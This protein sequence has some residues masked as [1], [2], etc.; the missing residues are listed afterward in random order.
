MNILSASKPDFFYPTSR[1]E[2]VLERMAKSHVTHLSTATF[3]NNH[4]IPNLRRSSHGLTRTSAI[5]RD[6]GREDI[7]QIQ[8]QNDIHP[9]NDVFLP[10]TKEQLP[11]DQRRSRIP[12]TPDFADKF[13]EQQSLLIRSLQYSEAAHHHLEDGDELYHNTDSEFFVHRNNPRSGEKDRIL[14]RVERVIPT[15]DNNVERNA[16]QQTLVRKRLA[17]SKSPTRFRESERRN[18]N[19]QIFLNEI[20]CMHRCDHPHI[21]KLVESYTD[22]NWFAIIM[23]PAAEM[24]LKQYMLSEP[25]H[26]AYGNELFSESFGCLLAALKHLAD[27]SIRHRDIKPENI[28]VVG[29]ERLVICDLGISLD[30]EEGPK[31]TDTNTLGTYK[32]KAPELLASN[33]EHDEKTDIWALA[34]VYVEMFTVMC[35]SKLHDLDAHLG[36]CTSE[37]APNHWAYHSCLEEVFD[38]LKYLRA[39]NWISRDVRQVIVTLIREMVR[40]STLEK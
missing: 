39:P 28:L 1:R 20:S 7:L 38:W 16:E 26:F 36:N 17:K 25:V 37:S 11:E 22:E 3:S 34:C 6:I 32:Y 5:L 29:R 24:N 33:H 18:R 35:G 21:V 10:F 23:T 15:L 12:S 9:F 19:A 4:T 27:R 40:F 30:Y 13:L 8:Y 2:P 14:D 31:T